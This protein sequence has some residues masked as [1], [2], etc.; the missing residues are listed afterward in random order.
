MNPCLL[1]MHPRH[2]HECVQ[3]LDELD[4]PKAWVSYYTEP[5]VTQQINQLIQAHDG[6]SHYLVVADDCQPTQDALD[7][8]VGQLAYHEVVTGYCNLD[9]TDERVNITRQPFPPDV[10][11]PSASAYDFYLRD[12]TDGWP[13]ATIPT[14]FVGMAFTAMP[15]QL[16]LDHPLEPWPRTDVASDAW[17]SVRLHNSRTPMVAARGAYVHHVKERWNLHDQE[18]RKRLLIG[19]EPPSVTW[20]KPP[21]PPIGHP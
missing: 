13:N 2:I 7:A 20:G 6:Y 4:I 15:R 5:G 3:A 9:A 1:I 11:A 10:S 16:W 14:W 21:N 19:Q 8:V 18:Q 17:L 12:E